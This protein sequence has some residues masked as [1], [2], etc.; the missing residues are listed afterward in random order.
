MLNWGFEDSKTGQATDHRTHSCWRYTSKWQSSCFCGVA[1]QG[2]H[3][4]LGNDSIDDGKCHSQTLPTGGCRIAPW[5]VCPRNH[6]LPSGI[7]ILV[8]IPQVDQVRMRALMQWQPVVGN[9]LPSDK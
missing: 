7:Q 3:I 1:N 5:W 4:Y 9:P 2:C 6:R 8:H